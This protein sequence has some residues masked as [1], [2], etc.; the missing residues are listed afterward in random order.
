M[1]VQWETHINWSEANTYAAV[2]GVR[3]EIT[4]NVRGTYNIYFGGTHSL[5]LGLDLILAYF[6]HCALWLRNK[7]Y[8]FD[9]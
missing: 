7:I 2:P 1:A 4:D 6:A 5:G 3:L 9:S 8:P